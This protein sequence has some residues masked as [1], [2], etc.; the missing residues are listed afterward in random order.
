MSASVI[1]WTILFSI[2]ASVAVV[3]IILGIIS[4]WGKE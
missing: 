1:I 2:I 3:Y 4:E